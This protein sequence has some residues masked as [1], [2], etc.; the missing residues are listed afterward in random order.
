MWE[1]TFEPYIQRVNFPIVRI[2]TPPLNKWIPI[3]FA[4]MHLKSNTQTLSEYSSWP[5]W[6]H[7]RT[8]IVL[9]IVIMITSKPKMMWNPLLKFEE[10][11]IFC[12]SCYNYAYTT[13]NY[14]LTTCNN[15]WIL[16]VLVH[17]LQPY[18]SQFLFFLRS[19]IFCYFWTLESCWTAKFVR[20]LHEFHSKTCQV[21]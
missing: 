21:N 10:W 4:T 19:Q 5:T 9:D 14:E 16:Q 6:K 12:K 13:W 17:I 7:A 20:R 15:V 8:K 2:L 3:Q 1:V 18:Y 11:P